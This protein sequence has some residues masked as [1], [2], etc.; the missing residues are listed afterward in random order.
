MD[1]ATRSS[2]REREKNCSGQC[3]RGYRVS[4]IT[5]IIVLSL[6]FVSPGFYTTFWQLS[7]YD[8]APPSSK[9]NEEGAKLRALSRQE[10]SNFNFADRSAGRI[11]RSTATTH[12]A[13][14]DRYNSF[15][16]ILAQEFKEQTILRQFTIRRLTKEKQC[17]FTHCE[18]YF[19]HNPAIY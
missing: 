8:I 17:W 16:N 2:V 5:N 1:S 19:F 9:Y 3:L 12:H 13:R 18:S 7:M 6:I 4:A 14:R 15:V 10:D 11:K